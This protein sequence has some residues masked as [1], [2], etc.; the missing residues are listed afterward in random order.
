MGF[1]SEYVWLGGKF[2]RFEDA[3]LHF[4]TSSLHYGTS[5]F[6]GIRSYKTVNGPAI[7]RLKD[8]IKRLFRSSDILGLPQVPYSQED[9]YQ[10]TLELVRLNQFEE[11]YIRPLIYISDGGWNLSVDN[12]KVDM[13][14]AVWKWTNYLGDDSLYHG[15]RANVS[16]YPRHHPN[17]SMTKGK[18]SGN[19]V[20]SVLAKTESLRAGFE[21]AIMLDHNGNVS[22]CT[23]EN[24]FIVRDNIIYT[25][26]R[27]TILEGI[28][29]ATVFK[30]ARDKGYQ[31]IEEEI[32]RDQLYLAEEVFITGTAAEVIALREID[33]RKIGTGSMG[34][35]C[36][37]IQKTYSD[38]IHGKLEQYYD[39]LDFVYSPEGMKEADQQVGFMPQ[40]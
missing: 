3:K 12:V 25:P 8:H 11:C 23:G 15:I 2:V 28:T 24:I 26:P 40:G 22:E 39:W 19:Y 35:I 9:V 5:V 29:R 30:L 38:L 18:I 4:L 34:P 37:D 1:E 21:E 6:E 27:T 7:F 33:H 20:N 14:I 31:V 10:D 17:I 16:S 36:T 13:G 32:T